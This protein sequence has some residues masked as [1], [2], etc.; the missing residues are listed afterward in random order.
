MIAAAAAGFVRS[1]SQNDPSVLISKSRS[2]SSELLECDISS[3][4]IQSVAP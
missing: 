4:R 1:S 3:D 2:D